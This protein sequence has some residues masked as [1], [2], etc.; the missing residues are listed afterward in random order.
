M[1]PVPV[2][3]VSGIP[4]VYGTS[5]L[6]SLLTIQVLDL[7]GSAEQAAIKFNLGVLI[8]IFSADESTVT[9]IRSSTLRSVVKPSRVSSFSV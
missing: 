6:L 4:Q 5:I 2:W 9:G 7:F 8:T 1:L 3:V